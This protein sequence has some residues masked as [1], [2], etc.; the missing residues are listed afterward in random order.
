MLLP[1]LALHAQEAEADEVMS[2][3]G[4][5]VLV[6]SDGKRYDAEAPLR[7]GLLIGSH[8][9][10]E[11]EQKIRN[12]L[13]SGSDDDL[14]VLLSKYHVDRL[15]GKDGS[16]RSNVLAGMVLLFVNEVDGQVKSV[17]MERG[18][19]EYKDVVMKVHRIVALDEDFGL[20][21]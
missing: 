15:T 19:K 2:V 16:F 13:R 4:N 12:C 5:V 18:K 14:D 21:R 3:H 8:E 6:N 11:A 17:T 1:V 10:A 9:A 20:C 7:Y